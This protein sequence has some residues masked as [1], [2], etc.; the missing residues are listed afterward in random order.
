[1]IY[2]SSAGGV[3][4]QE[5]GY[6]Q[7]GHAQAAGWI[8]Q[9]LGD[10]WTIT[11]PAPGWAS[12]DDAIRDLA[13][14]VPLT[15][16]AVLEVGNWALLLNNGPDGTDVGVMPSRLAR[17]LGRRAIRA[18]CV[19]DKEAEFPGRILE[20]Y[21]PNGN[22]PLLCERSIAAAKDGARWVFETS[23]TPFDFEDESQYLNRLVAKRLTCDLLY[24]YLRQLRVPID[25]E[26][27]WASALVVEKR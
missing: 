4:T 26:P 24:E 14:S 19:G 27:D 6:L 16:H 12:L 18:V 20:V 15:K 8:Q 9:G 2:P 1:M 23:G 22:P 7:I 3:T 21:G 10:G 17:D 5:V 11:Q 13:P 25:K